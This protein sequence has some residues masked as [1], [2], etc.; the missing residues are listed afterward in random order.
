MSDS[1][2]F[3]SS[4]SVKTPIKPVAKTGGDSLGFGEPVVQ[5]KA[6]VAPVKPTS[7][8][9]LVLAPEPKL[10]DI[11]FKSEINKIKS[12]FEATKAPIQKFQEKVTSKKPLFEDNSVGGIVLN[13]IKGL[14]KEALNTGIDIAQGIA[15]TVAQVGITTGNLP[16]KIVNKIGGLN[17][18][19]PFDQEIDTTG[20]KF[21]KALFGGKPIK[22]VEKTVS[23]VKE[24]LKPFIGEKASDYSALPLVLGSIAL[25][26][27][28]LGGKA[29]VKSF[30]SGEIPEAFFKY[31]AKTTDETAVRNTLRSIGLDDVRSG[32]LAPRLAETKT[33]DEV[34]DVLLRFENTDNAAQAVVK[35]LDT[36]A[37]KTTAPVEVP[38]SLLPI[39][40]KAENLS[41]EQFTDMFQKGLTTQNLTVRDSANNALKLM[42]EAGYN[43]PEEFY[44]SVKKTIP[45]EITSPTPQVITDEKPYI[46][47]ITGDT[48]DIKKLSEPE[49]FKEAYRSVFAQSMPT[50]EKLYKVLTKELVP[51]GKEASSYLSDLY[52]KTET[53]VAGPTE[54]Q[55]LIA[56]GKL[57]VKTLDGQKVYK[58]EE[59]GKTV[60]TTS[61]E[62]AVTRLTEG[63]V[64]QY[65]APEIS[66]EEEAYRESIRSEIGSEAKSYGMSALDEIADQIVNGKLRIGTGK[67]MKTE[68]QE[69][70]GGHYMRLFTKDPN[71]QTLDE[72]VEQARN[73]GEEVTS[74]D[75]IE[76]INDMIAEK[77]ARV[78]QAREAKE[79]IKRKIQV[80]KDKTE[81]KKQLLQTRFEEVY[82]KT[83]KEHPELENPTL[84]E[85]MSIMAEADNNK[86]YPFADTYI[87]PFV[88]DMVKAQTPV[89]KK[90]HLFDYLQTPENVLKKIGL[91]EAMKTV[92]KGFESASAELPLQIEIVKDWEKRVLEQTYK[93][94]EVQRNMP[95]NLKIF[96]YLDGNLDELKFPLTKTEFQVAT[97]IK[98]YLEYWAYRLNL[99]ED[100]RLSHYITHIFDSEL[101]K[102]EFDED[103]VKIISDKQPSEVYDPF[104]QERLG[105]KGY[106]QDTWAALDAYIKRGVRKANMDPALEILKK[107]AE[108]LED[109]SAKYVQRY[110]EGI[111][112]RPTEIDTGMDNFLKNLPIIGYKFGQRPTMNI[113]RSLRQM[114]YRGTLG[115][116]V[117]NAMKNLTQGVNTYSVLGEKY[118]TLG[119]IKLMTNRSLGKELQEVGVLGQDMIQDR[120]L[121]TNQAFW[122]KFWEKFDSGLFMLQKSTEFINRGAAYAGAKTKALDGN[123][124]IKDLE[125]ALGKKITDP[126]VSLEDAIE[127][128]KS[129][130]RKTQFNFGSID[131]PVAM[132]GDIAKSIFQLTTFPI[133]QAE[134][135]K[136]MAQNKDFAGMIRYI[137]GAFL[138]VSTIGKAFNLKASDFNP[139]TIFSRFGVP[140]LKLPWS[141]TKAIFNLPDQYGKIPTTKAKVKDVVYNTTSY[142]PGGVQLSKI[143]KGKGVLGTKKTTKSSSK[144][145]S[146]KDSLGF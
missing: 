103:L 12:N 144:S 75:L 56:E 97:E 81:A 100:S 10:G 67:T 137:F 131:A 20:N 34:K 117:T 112:F 96:K 38:E 65:K 79:E 93:R 115:G 41:V 8:T 1:L 101:L 125:K 63:P 55:K 39:A 44:N 142:F 120:N 27:S 24:F 37:P 58:F 64:T 46:R 18:E 133:K 61:E 45:E 6:P 78:D 42:K 146:G 89:S 43:N 91:E 121:T 143:L 71:A 98:D 119:Y 9:P 54:A 127:Y 136:N 85:T 123:V 50:D 82:K 60:T 132:R 105:A 134:F 80:L 92:R 74:D 145:S 87:R 135:L 62:E 7:S 14:P 17:E 102:K 3:N 33:V 19:L 48:V 23:D 109:Y 84:D 104:L 15:R 16:T 141:I 36:K 68:A 70:L 2:G 122:S 21:T 5:T 30:T 13:T 69:L 72:L 128:A 57:K 90:V 66:A 73:A 29:G 53:E 108:H 76:K 138:L 31:M 107:D 110:A 118:T 25:D 32:I 86:D 95:A 47:T 52:K 4:S 77:K 106:K 126:N 28:G 40:K 113:T 114:I 49:Y 35:Q 59:E 11:S 26:L 116:N 22:T 140:M 94:G 99:P 139:L 130:V 111:N 83:L 88:G 51:E 124:S 129:V